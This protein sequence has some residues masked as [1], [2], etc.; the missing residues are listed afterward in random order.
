MDSSERNQH[1]TSQRNND[2]SIPPNI[3]I[4]SV[5]DISIESG[6]DDGDQ[7]S[8]VPQDKKKRKQVIYTKIATFGSMTEAHESLIEEGFKKHEKKDV[9]AGRKTYYR[10]G[11]IKQKSKHQCEAKRMIF[12]DNTTI[13]F[14]VYQSDTDHTCDSIDLNEKVKS[15]SNEMKRMI[16][17]CHEL[18]MSPKYIIIHINKL[19]E[20]DGLFSNEVTPTAQQM[21]YIIR[22]HKEKSNPKMVFLGQLIDW[23]EKNEAVPDDE[24]TPF[25]IGFEHSSEE[26][27]LDFKIVVSTKRLLNHCVNEKQLCVDATYKLNWNG[28]PFMV[29]GTVDRHRKFQ[30]LCFALCVGETTED[31]GFIFKSMVESIKSLFQMDFEPNILICDASNAIRNAFFDIFPSAEL[32]IMCYVHVLRNIEKNRDKYKKEHKKEILHD[33]EILH[34]AS[35]HKDFEMLSKLFLKKWAKKDK[36]FADYFKTIWLLSHCNWYTAAGASTYTPSTNNSLEG[37]TSI[38]LSFH[39]LLFL[40]LFSLFFFTLQRKFLFVH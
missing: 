38:F 16:I 2:K 8:N 25:V 36:E 28:F 27:K 3:S 9:K 26:A 10:C 6:S 33:I 32:I 12:E 29:I 18:R 22:A 35:S 15:I 13:D 21:H 40:Y 14:D 34:Q 30:P 24:D 1:G 37:E 7:V 17:E 23:C 4:V 39:I 19:R 31:F 11:N 20:N 5:L